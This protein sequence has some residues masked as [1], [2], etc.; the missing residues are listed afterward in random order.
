MADIHRVPVIAV[1]K[2]D[3]RFTTEPP[4]SVRAVKL[5]IEKNALKL[6]RVG[7]HEYCTL[8]EIARA[9]EMQDAKAKE[10]I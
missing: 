7:Q 1:A 6:H 2:A 9:I 10:I 3:V 4:M 5:L 8:V